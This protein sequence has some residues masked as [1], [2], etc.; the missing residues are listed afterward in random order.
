MLRPGKCWLLLGLVWLSGCVTWVS[1]TPLPEPSEDW[2][3]IPRL[4]VVL[5]SHFNQ[6]LS[7]AV[8]PEL[9]QA[10][11]GA[12][13]RDVS[14]EQRYFAQRGEGLEAH[15]LELWGLVEDPSQYHLF[16]GVPTVV[17]ERARIIPPGWG[18]L[19]LSICTL[20]LFPVVDHDSG[21]HLWQVTVYTDKEEP[22]SSFSV[23]WQP[24]QLRFLLLLPAWPFGLIELAVREPPYTF[25]A[26]AL[27]ATLPHHLGP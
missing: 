17:I 6:K 15:G 21:S 2:Q 18:K 8:L 25:L 13:A 14:I 7:S 1:E 24:M 5:A 20:T 3:P 9:R 11:L 23:A 26:R 10:L 12:V 22:S 16:T 19:L 4:D 27:R